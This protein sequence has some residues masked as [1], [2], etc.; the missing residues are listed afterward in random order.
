MENT[1]ANT[2]SFPIFSLTEGISIMQKSIDAT[3]KSIKAQET[4][5][6]LV[7]QSI[8]EFA[9]ESA[10]VG[11]QIQTT[12]LGSSKEKS[13]EESS[14]PV[15]SLQDFIANN[16][17]FLPLAPA[18][19]QEE[20]NATRMKELNDIIAAAE[21][22]R[23]NLKAIDEKKLSADQK[24]AMKQLLQ[25]INGAKSERKNLGSQTVYEDFDALFHFDTMEEEVSSYITGIWAKV[26]DAMN[27]D[28][29]EEGDFRGFFANILDGFDGVKEIIGGVIGNVEGFIS[30]VKNVVEEHFGDI[31]S[32]GKGFFQTFSIMT[33]EN[34]ETVEENAE[35]QLDVLKRQIAEAKELRDQQLQEN[36]SRYDTEK[37][38]LEQLYAQGKISHEDYILAGK[39]LDEEKRAADE[40]ANAGVIDLER[41]LLDVENAHAKTTFENNKRQNLSEA[42]MS[43]AAAFV[44][45]LKIGPIMGP[46][47]A[48]V[49]ATMVAAQLAA[50]NGQQFTPKTA[51][52]QGGIVS[53]PTTALIGEGGEPEMVLPLSKAKDMG[54]A[55]RNETRVI[56]NINAPTYT[57]EDLTDRVYDGIR[58]A[59]RTGRLPRWA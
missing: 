44:Q 40:T 58:L 3:E 17:N 30:E 45:A 10:S 33:E 50:I 35:N 28:M 55:G 14:D 21:T 27:F 38:S 7:S 59:Q 2:I 31:I 41:Q 57:G 51:L 22:L 46:I 13:K 53:S 43:G 47:A 8:Q 16:S 42:A 32:F 34:T 37:D 26:S 11:K 4:L 39:T 52:A 1:K 20:Q 12:V 49:I 54:F 29:L 24:S 18:P 25:I 15:L 5:G 19:T 23:E 48:A 6:K 56:I 9:V 36:Q